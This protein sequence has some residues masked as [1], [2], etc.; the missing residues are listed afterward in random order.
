M[1]WS[2]IFRGISFIV[3]LLP[4][5]VLC[6]SRSYKKSESFVN[7]MCRMAFGLMMINE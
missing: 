7:V 6:D 4:A 5:T 3:V 1:K 2:I